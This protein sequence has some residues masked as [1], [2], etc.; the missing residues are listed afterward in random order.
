MYLVKVRAS[1]LLI[2]HGADVNDQNG[3]DKSGLS[4]AASVGEVGLIQILLD[5]GAAIDHADTLGIT[6][7]L[8]CQLNKNWPAVQLLLDRGANVVTGTQIDN[9][10]LQAS[11]SH[12]TEMVKLLLEGARV[13]SPFG[14]PS[15]LYGA[16]SHWRYTK[17][18]SD[19]EETV[20]LLLEAGADPNA[21]FHR[22]D[23]PQ[24]SQTPL[25]VASENASITAVKLLF[26]HGADL[27]TEIERMWSPLI[28][29][30]KINSA[31]MVKLLLERGC[32]PNDLDDFI[33]API[34]WAA[35]HGDNREK[36]EALISYG[37]DINASDSHLETP[38]MMATR[39][40]NLSMVDYLLDQGST[41]SA[42]DIVGNTAL[43]YASGPGWEEVTGGKCQAQ[44][45]AHGNTAV[46]PLKKNADLSACF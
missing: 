14:G 2:D 18:E 16:L 35:P 31:E 39:H 11:R 17:H 30:V 6:P 26:D 40:G 15:P 4:L 44:K 22:G 19:D 7:L 32:N 28:G 42:E 12:D 29:A 3:Q 25:M 23:A 36:V 1:K 34:S 43:F 8:H 5:S 10:L 45:C 33:K 21:T 38:L 20:R 37:A 46:L 27:K 13:E 24:F 41:V 9:P